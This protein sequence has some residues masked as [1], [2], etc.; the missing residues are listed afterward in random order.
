ME[1]LVKWRPWDAAAFED[2]R[3]EG[4]PVLLGISA[5]WCHWCHVMDRG[6][7]GSAIHTGVYNNPA[8]A[9]IINTRFIPVRVDNDLRPDINARY[10][11]GGWPTTCFLT[12]DGQIFYGGTYFSPAQMRNLL[13]QIERYW[14]TNREQLLASAPDF[15][16]AESGGPGDL[17]AGRAL[18]DTVAA[19]TRAFDTKHGGLGDT[20]KFPMPEAW[21]T[22]L[23]GYHESGDRR[24]LD[25]T[26]QTLIAMGTRGMYDRAAGGWFRYSTTPDWSVPHFEKMLEDYARL[27]PV[28]VH[29]IQILRDLPDESEAAQTL[30]SV[31][32]G[33]LDY[34]KGTLLREAGD[35]AWF[36][37][38]QD[39]DEAYYLLSRSER[40]TRKAPFIDERLHTDWNALMVNALLEAAATLG[41]PDLTELARRVLATLE[42]VCV[43]ADGAVT[44]SLA[45]EADGTTRSFALRG[46]LV[47]QSALARA[48][49]AAGRPEAAIRPLFDYADRALAAAGGGYHD[50]PADPNALGLLKARL[51]P[52]AENAS[53]ADALLRAAHAWPG[54]AGLADKAREALAVFADSYAKFRE[55]GGAFALA[56][57]RAAS[58]PEEWVAVGAPE[59]TAPFLRAAARRYHPWRLLRALDPAQPAD[60]AL[61]AVR[62]F[63]LA[64]LPAA[65][66]CRGTACSAPLF[67]ADQV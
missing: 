36:A 56:A 11:Q 46:A 10:N 6:E 25:M 1:T 60:A 4:K 20:Q 34:L 33:A 50:A 18:A 43:G 19:I 3:A 39:A 29:A 2:A 15:S 14:Q 35:L 41:R 16:V 7:P 38:S 51:R 47:D 49:L 54:A 58:E 9:E 37:G 12:P 22:L 42:R 59:Q 27:L 32:N 57:Y 5:V 67:E 65:F 48:M 13:S 26:V 17:D 52:M 62:G 24:L 31:I 40:A 61:I 44:H 66:V 30:T 8:L 55:H 64:R 23:V 53:M 45:I 63:P 28:Y 21:E